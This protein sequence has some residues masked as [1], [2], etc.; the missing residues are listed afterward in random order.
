MHYHT[1]KRGPTTYQVKL[2]ASSMKVSNVIEDER[3]TYW[4]C[5]VKLALSRYD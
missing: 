4:D 1:D 5:P 2:M 3:T